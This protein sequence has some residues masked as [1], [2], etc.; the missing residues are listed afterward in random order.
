[1]CEKLVEKIARK[2]RPWA[3]EA[4]ADPK[5]FADAIIDAQTA[6]KVIEDAGF[7]IA[8]KETMVSNSKLR[9][10][11]RDLHYR[12]QELEDEC[13]KTDL[14]RIRLLRND[15][16]LEA[17]DKAQLIEK[18]VRLEEKYRYAEL[19][20]CVVGYV[21]DAAK[22]TFAGNCTFVDE[23]LHLMTFC[24]RWALENGIPDDLC[25]NIFPKAKAALRDEAS[26]QAED[27]PSND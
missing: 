27:E 3:F 14:D 4:E 11:I 10:T 19:D 7:E 8:P 5:E 23:D 25:P 13:A 18:I 20:G 15:A 24:A 21:R 1:M 12:I 26:Q 2:I 17:M 22:D 9:R 6:L 16:D